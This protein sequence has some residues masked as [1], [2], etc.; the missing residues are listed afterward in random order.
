MYFRW[1]GIILSFAFTAMANANDDY[2]NAHS[3]HM[4]H[5]NRPQLATGVAF[6]PDGSLWIVGLNEKHKL[7]IQNSPS[8]KLSDWSEQKIL[9]TGNDQ[10]SA[11]G[12]NRPKI[13]FGPNG[14]VV[15]SYTEPHA[16]PYTGFIR[17]MR[18][19]DGG[20]SF[21]LPFT[22]HRDRNE[23]THRFESIVFDKIGQL[24]TLWIDKRDQ[25]PKNSGINYVGAAVYRNVS[26]DGGKT[27]GPDIK[28]A[29][30][31][32]ECCRIAITFNSQGQLVALW[33]HV[34]GDKT[35]DHA[36][37]NISAHQPNEVVRASYDDWQID[38]CPH[39]GPGIAGNVV[40]GVTLGYHAVWF[41]IRQINGEN[42]AAVRYGRL[43]ANGQPILDSVRPLP[44]TRAEH[45]DVISYGNKVAIVWRSTE[46]AVTKLKAWISTD[47]G[48]HFKESELSQVT[49][50]NDHPRLA[51]INEKMVIVWRSQDRVQVYEL[52]F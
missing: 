40:D 29:D 3:E 4:S 12:E 42:I 14:W 44:D 41:G 35:R 49:G 5:S 27:F 18:S 33:R 15:I 30:H 10:V 23:I 17:M 39:H 22:F 36:F 32:C 7:F 47:S 43:D 21:S 6:A 25:P 51:Q 9:D 50:Y 46:G 20:N 28:V 34:F 13:A 37:S 1:I 26:T 8:G 16:K 19:D 2:S 24:H 11:D 45:A 52:A 48:N 38:A 31:S